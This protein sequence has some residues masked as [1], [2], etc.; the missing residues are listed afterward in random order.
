MKEVFLGS[1][2]LMMALIALEVGES[3][4]NSMH[5]QS[6]LGIGFVLFV[7]TYLINS[8]AEYI[9]FRFSKL[10]VRRS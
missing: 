4:W 1:V 3:S 8:T 5:Y 9:I 2:Y 7:M 10:E 6:L